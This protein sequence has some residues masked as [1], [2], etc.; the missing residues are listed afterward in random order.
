MNIFFF[1]FGKHNDVVSVCVDRWRHI[2]VSPSPG[3]CACV[4]MDRMERPHLLPLT[5][6]PRW[7]LSYACVCHVSKPLL[8]THSPF[9][10]NPLVMCNTHNHHSHSWLGVCA[11]RHSQ[12]VS[13]TFYTR[14]L[15]FHLETRQQQRRTQSSDEF[16]GVKRVVCVWLGQSI[17]RKIE[18][19]LRIE[20]A[21]PSCRTKR[22]ELN[23]KKNRVTSACS[24]RERVVHTRYASWNY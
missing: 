5:A 23:R 19:I 8:R 9:E 11:P 10:L 20:R 24:A 4:R 1:L 3:M 12:K 17:N 2:S 7:L 14:F 22:N 15:I 13:E 6:T 21:G 16:L 18:E